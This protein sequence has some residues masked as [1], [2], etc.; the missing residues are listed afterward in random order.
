MQMDPKR[1][2]HALEPKPGRFKRDAQKL[3]KAEAIEPAPAA[4]PWKARLAAALHPPK[5]PFVPLVQGFQRRA[6]E[7]YGQGPSVRAVMAPLGQRFPLAEIG[8]APIC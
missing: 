6:P 2:R 1:P 4:E 8:P 5:G 3:A 7:H